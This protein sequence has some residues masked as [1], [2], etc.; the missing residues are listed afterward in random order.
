MPPDERRSPMLLHVLPPVERQPI[1]APIRDMRT[2]AAGRQPMAQCRAGLPV[3]D[4]Q[5]QQTHCEA[6]ASLQSVND[7]P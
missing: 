4:E 5:R 6:A 2:V 1:G 7:T 3:A